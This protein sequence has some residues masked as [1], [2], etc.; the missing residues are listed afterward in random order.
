MN[1]V[2]NVADCLAKETRELNECINIR[3]TLDDVSATARYPVRRKSIKKDYMICDHNANREL[4][5]NVTQ[6]MTEH[7]R[8]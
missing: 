4:T 3:V 8:E 2:Y 6:L 5:K 7:L 1:T